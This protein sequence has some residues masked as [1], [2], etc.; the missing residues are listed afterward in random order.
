MSTNSGD[1]L[2]LGHFHPHDHRDVHNF[3]ELRHRHLS[4]HTR[5]CKRP[6]RELQRLQ[7][8]EL[9]CLLHACTRE[10]DRHN[11]DIDHLVNVQQLENLWRTMGICLCATTEMSTTCATGM[12]SDGATSLHIPQPQE[13]QLFVSLFG[14]LLLFV[15]CCC[16]LLFVAVC[17]CCVLL[18]VVVCVVVCVCVCVVVCCCVLVGGCLLFV[19][20]CVCVF[21]CVCVCLCVCVC[22]VLFCVCFVLFCFVLFCF[23]LFC[24]CFVLFCVC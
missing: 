16:L 21:V 13:L 6:C 5:A 20:V 7:L 15:V 22:F 4:L 1:E 18:C 12:S 23:V 9:G 10:L 24:V 19:C 14:C 2:N 11:K 8:W 17:C 3:V